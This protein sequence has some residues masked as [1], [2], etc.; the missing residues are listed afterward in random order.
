MKKIIKCEPWV[1]RRFV[2]Q[3]FLSFP[4][5]NPVRARSGRLRKELC[6]QHLRSLWR[7]CFISQAR[8]WTTNRVPTPQN[9]HS[10]ERTGM[11]SKLNHIQSWSELARQANWSVSAL[12][13]KC[14][15]SARTLERYFLKDMGKCP[16][17]WLSEQR[18]LLASK[19]LL[20]GSSVKETAACLGYKNQH[21]FSRDFKKQYGRPPSQP[22]VQSK[23]KV[24]RGCRI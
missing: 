12:A 8:D 10:F 11:N 3:I 21:H 22:I 4:G 18:Q 23:F 24:K 19:L 15:V 20:D 14:G 17:A 1:S 5:I 9:G 13:K 7:T 6:N 16:K 2:P